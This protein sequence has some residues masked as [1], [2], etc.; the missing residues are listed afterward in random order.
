MNN[1]LA[2]KRIRQAMT[3]LSFLL[4]LYTAGVMLAGSLHIV[5]SGESSSFLQSIPHAP[6]SPWMVF[7]LSFILCSLLSWLILNTVQGSKS[8]I[9]LCAGFKTL[10]ACIIIWNVNLSCRPLLL[11]VFSDVLYTMRGF[12]A[13]YMVGI[14]SILTGL[15]LLFSYEVITPMIP[16]VSTG[17]Y[18]SV[19][20]H[21]TASLLAFGQSLLESATLVLFIAFMCE[22]LIDLHQEKENIAQELNMMNRVN[23]DLRHYAQ[24]TEQIAESRERKRLAREIHDTL[25]HA[26]TGIAAGIDATLVIMDKNPEMA[27]SQLHLVR[28]VVSEGIGDVRASLQKLRP[29]ALEQRGLKGALEKMIRE[30]ESVT[31]MTIDLDYQADSLDVDKAKEDVCFR[32][33][34]ESI[35]NARRHGAATHAAVR[36]AVDG[37]WLVITVRD[38]GRGL[39]QKTITYGYGLTQMEE[40]VSSLHGTLL[41]DGSDGFLTEARIPLT[42]GEYR[43]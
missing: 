20:E 1:M 37:D 9:L 15:Y 36:F 8:G 35:T 27:K 30:F 39:P 6:S 13:R 40:N 16:M 22:F 12:Q 5:E 19:F 42:K 14:G 38:N 7:W 21:S 41:F 4:V 11:L 2:M 24:M 25:G 18:F 26:L 28:Q 43:E 31:A 34:Q 32:L 10:L 23:E 3:A 29:G 33:V 17:A